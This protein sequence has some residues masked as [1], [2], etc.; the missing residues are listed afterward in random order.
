MK[1][2]SVVLFQIHRLCGFLSFPFVYGVEETFKRVHINPYILIL[3][4]DGRFWI[5]SSVCKDS[6]ANLVRGSSNSSIQFWGFPIHS[7]IV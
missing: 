2:C 5:N 6:C 4:L 7:E 1:Q 3:P